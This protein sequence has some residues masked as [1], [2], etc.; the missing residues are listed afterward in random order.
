[1]NFARSARRLKH[2]AFDLLPV[3]SPAWGRVLLSRPRTIEILKPFEVYSSTPAPV[4]LH[5]LDGAAGN[6]RFPS[7][8]GCADI[9]RFDADSVWCLETNDRVSDLRILATGSVVLNRRFHLDLDFTPVKGLISS[10]RLLWSE[11]ALIACWPHGWGSYY[12]FVMNIVTKLVRIEHALGPSVWTQARLAYPRRHAAYEPEFLQELGIEVGSHVVRIGDV[13]Y[14]TPEEWAARRDAL[15][16]AGGASAAGG[17]V[18]LPPVLAQD[19]HA[20]SGQIDDSEF[21]LVDIG[22]PVA[23]V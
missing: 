2:L 17:G 7:G 12:D 1:M 6:P 18:S 21:E 4:L 10:H 5:A 9:L 14:E 15:I 11:E 8:G 13:G 23:A 20:R 16:A 19:C 3:A 22:I